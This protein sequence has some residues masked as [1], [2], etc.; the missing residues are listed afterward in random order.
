MSKDPSYRNLLQEWSFTTASLQLPAGGAT[1]S[2]LLDRQRGA[3]TL[4]AVR[5]PVRF[6]RRPDQAVYMRS[7]AVRQDQ[8]RTSSPLLDRID[9]HMKVPRMVCQRL[10]DNRLGEPTEAIWARVERAREVRR[11]RF[12]RDRALRVG[13]RDSAHS[14]RFSSLDSCIVCNA[15][16]RVAEIG[17]WCNQ[18]GAGE[19]RVRAAMVHAEVALMRDMSMLAINRDDT[20]SCCASV[21]H[22]T[23][24]L[25]K[26][27]R[28]RRL[29]PS[30]AT[31]PY[32]GVHA[33]SVDVHQPN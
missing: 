5:L 4:V 18:D 2:R 19:S 14:S 30:S 11:K 12:S 31:Y 17:P 27:G 32:E 15:G 3:G 10:S 24:R 16:M 8:N 9:I 7:S 23:V 33:S 25:P 20:R 13:S 26:N 28:R 6:L 21:R 22:P 1:T 29:A